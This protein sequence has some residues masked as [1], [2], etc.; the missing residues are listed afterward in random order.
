M[1]R[2]LEEIEAIRERGVDLGADIYPY[3]AASQGLATEVPRW[4]Q[5]GG[6]EKFLARLKDPALRPRL[7][8]ETD[9]YIE[10]KY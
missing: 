10:T 5:D 6:R 4:A 2:A 9:A 3:I 8:K 7:R 1:A